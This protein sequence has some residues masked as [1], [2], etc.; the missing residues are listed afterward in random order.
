MN[1]LDSQM[2]LKYHGK[3]VNKRINPFKEDSFSLGLLFLQ[4][5]TLH[6]DEDLARDK[7]LIRVG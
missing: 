6:S 7:D 5:A 1:V 2:K 3:N 4:M